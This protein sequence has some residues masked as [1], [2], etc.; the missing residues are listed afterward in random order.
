MTAAPS[1]RYDAIVVG[2]GHNGLVCAAYLARDGL[3]TLLVE[4]RE[5]V[6][7]AVGTHELMAGV[8]VPDLAH[9]V[10]RLAP[11]IARDLDLR[12]HR[13]RLVQPDAR[14]LAL[15][16]DARP[17]TLWGDPDRTAQ[18]LADLS[19]ADA[20]RY[21]EFDTQ[22]RA[23]SGL[24]GRLMAMTPPDPSRPGIAD[25]LTGLRLG[26][27]YR[28]LGAVHGRALLRVL[29]MPIAD[30]LEDWFT[31]PELRAALAWR[32]VRYSSLGPRDAGTSQSFLADSARTGSG[33]AGDAVFVRGGPGAL[34]EGLAS[35]ARGFGCTIWTSA[36]ARSI[37][38]RDDRASGVVLSDGRE[39][40]AGT[41]VSGLDPKRT[42]LEL[43][44]PAMLGPLLGWQ[45][46]NLR[47]KGSVSKVDLA[48]ADLPAFTGMD[49]AAD[50][51]RTRGRI[52]V[53]PSVGALDRAADSVK[54]GRLAEHPLLEATI[55][56]LIDASLVQPG[57]QARH[58]MS[59][60]VQ[61]TPYHRR[62]GKS[63][64][65]EREA[66][67]DAVVAELE[68]VA[69]GIGRLIVGRR[70]VTPLDL[71]RGYGL[72]EGHPLHGEPA[73]DQWFARRPMLGFARYR[74]PVEGLY[75]CGSGAHPGGGVTGW[76]GRNAARE[77]I[78]DRRR[79]P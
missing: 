8:R 29:P 53:L 76:P 54:A 47:Q 48:L 43:V 79:R 77:I 62:D 37:A 4:R 31:S 39:I 19:A 3:R 25:A 78:A 20:A 50:G 59:I 22:T 28:G 24:L 71:E 44:D 10:G 35:A 5:H 40:H 9:A 12:G 49:G 69:P 30:H 18:G 55:P 15:S 34:A 72:T 33:A 16:P 11:T 57:A 56:S 7:G 64:D 58:V 60:L 13:V 41:I 63:W 46:G 52:L 6:G 17:L 23:L 70:V 61:G 73:L 27:R 38:I 26:V 74:L 32:G 14:M 21:R 51:S 42:L 68:A 75:L 67:G 2:G 45:V 66:L 1:A 65:T 36:E